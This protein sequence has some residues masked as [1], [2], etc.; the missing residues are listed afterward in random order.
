[1]IQ[2]TGG[3]T[4]D[5]RRDYD[6]QPHTFVGDRGRLRF[7][8]YVSGYPPPTVTLRDF[9]DAILIGALQAKNRGEDAPLIE[10]IDSPTVLR[11]ELNRDVDFS[12]ISAAQN[13]CCE[14]ERRLGIYPN[15]T[16]SYEAAPEPEPTEPDPH[17][18]DDYRDP[19]LLD[20]GT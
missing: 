7:Y 5:P 20:D 13:A 6:G 18:P 1:M 2:P 3:P 9:Y 14:I 10:S 8:A 19:D 12:L 16:L 15:V 17:D 11:E 4:F